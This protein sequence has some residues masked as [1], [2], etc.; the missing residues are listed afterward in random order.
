MFVSHFDMWAKV[1]YVQHG[2]RY[3]TY[4]SMHEVFMNDIC[5]SLHFTCENLTTN[6]PKWKWNSLHFIWKYTHI[7]FSY[8]KFGILRI[9][10]TKNWV[11]SFPH[12]IW[13][14][15]YF[16]YE[17]QATDFNTQNVEFWWFHI[18]NSGHWFSSVEDGFLCISHK[19]ILAETYSMRYWT[20]YISFRKLWAMIFLHEI[21]ISPLWHL[22]L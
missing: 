6:V 11:L 1:F 9:S 7:L 8:V 20:F 12:E 10:H 3:F 19:K 5:N 14:F 21:R 16:T 2:T 17:H 18:C 13:S 4:E 15:V 22:K